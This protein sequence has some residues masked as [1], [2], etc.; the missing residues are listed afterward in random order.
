MEGVGR[1]LRFATLTICTAIPFEI[2]TYPTRIY[3]AVSTRTWGCTGLEIHLHALNEFLT[4]DNCYVKD[5]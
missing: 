5:K 1:D 2:A 4:Y 3:P